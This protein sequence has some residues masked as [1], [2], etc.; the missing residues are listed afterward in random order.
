MNGEVGSADFHH[1]MIWFEDIQFFA[2]FSLISPD[3]ARLQ[4]RCWLRASLM[5]FSALINLWSIKLL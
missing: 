5:V 2:Q 4:W 3:L 1:L